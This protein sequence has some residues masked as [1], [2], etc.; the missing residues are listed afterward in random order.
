MQWSI[1]IQSRIA[2]DD[3]WIGELSPATNH[4]ISVLLAAQHNA[5]M[6]WNRYFC[7]STSDSER[8]VIT[9]CCVAKPVEAIQGDDQVAGITVAG[10]RM[11][12]SRPCVLTV[13]GGTDLAVGHQTTGRRLV[14][15]SISGFIVRWFGV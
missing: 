9:I 12:K 3:E 5:K 15:P 14:P 4:A 13:S 6:R 1:A 11:I 7:I 8:T 2:G 10:P